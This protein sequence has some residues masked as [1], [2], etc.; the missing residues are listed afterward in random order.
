MGF[1]SKPYKYIQ[2]F[3]LMHDGRW[4]WFFVLRI[5]RRISFCFEL[6]KGKWSYEGLHRR[7]GTL[8]RWLESNQDCHLWPKS[9][10]LA[11]AQ[12]S[13]FTTF[14]YSQ[15]PWMSQRLIATKV[16]T[17][18]FSSL[19]TGV[20]MLVLLIQQGL[21]KERTERNGHLEG[22]LITVILQLPFAS[23]Y[24]VATSTQTLA[25]KQADLQWEAES[26]LLPDVV[27]VKNR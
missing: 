10:L 21:T 14:A 2:W 18:P 8:F 1:L 11:L 22:S 23:C 24:N 19:R 6:S 7:Q 3:S 4:S 26:K 16:T 17:M 12:H 5:F 15:M 9:K 13:L 20:K 27:S 25:R